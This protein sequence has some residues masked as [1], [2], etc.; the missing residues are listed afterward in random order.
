MK[1][2]NKVE[3]AGA[4]AGHNGVHISDL[5]VRE[6]VTTTSDATV[7]EVRASLTENGIHAMPVVDDA[8]HPVGI[9]SATDLLGP[10]ETVTVDTVMTREV[11]TIP[12]YSRVHDAARLM[13]SKHIHHL[14][15]T[16]EQKIVGIL[17]SF[18]ILHLVADKRFVMKEPATRRKRG[19]GGRR[20]S[21]GLA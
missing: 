16:N 5:M 13:L 18:D 3:E 8:N 6:V 12:A 2:Q 7:G 21:E 10:E 15:V 9:V 14:I 17:S 4:N 19:G 11:Q 20:K 1:R